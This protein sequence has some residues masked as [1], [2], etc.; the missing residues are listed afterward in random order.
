MVVILTYIRGGR[1]QGCIHGSTCHPSA[2]AICSSPGLARH[3]LGSPPRCAALYQAVLRA[4]LPLSEAILGMVTEQLPSPPAAAPERL[5]RLLPAQ[6]DLSEL[7]PADAGRVRAMVR[8]VNAS[9]GC[10]GSGD[11]APVVVYV[12]KMISVPA[13]TLPRYIT[14]PVAAAPRPH[15]LAPIPATRPPNSTLVI[16]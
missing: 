6:P 14:S 2:I 12:S 16:D 11:D 9:V 4:W 8:R 3:T 10:C 5:A 13:T 15:P 7:P 1:L